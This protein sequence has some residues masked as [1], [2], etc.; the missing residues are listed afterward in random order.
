MEPLFGT[1]SLVVGSTRPLVSLAMIY[2][3]KGYEM[4]LLA[5]PFGET[6]FLVW[7]SENP[8]VMV[9][10]FCCCSLSWVCTDL[11]YH[12]SGHGLDHDQWTCSKFKS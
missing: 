8:W 3:V 11:N 6:S 2:L 10:V 5:W 1:S 4:V 7:D 12:T 9:D